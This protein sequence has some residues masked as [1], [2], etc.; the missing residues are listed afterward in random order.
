MFCW[1][2]NACRSFTAASVSA[3]VS[4]PGGASA[5]ERQLRVVGEQRLARRFLLARVAQ[6]HVHRVARDGDLL[7]LDARVAQLLAEVALE[8]LHELGDGALGVDLVDEQH[9]AAQVEAEAH[10]LE[11]ERVQ[12]VGRAGSVGQR[13]GVLALRSGTGSGRAPRAGHPPA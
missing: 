11:A 9:A 1:I 8:P 5:R 10:R 13:D 3:T 12:P 6:R 4:V 7:V 2:A